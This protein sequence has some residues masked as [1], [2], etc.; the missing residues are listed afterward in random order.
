MLESVTS[1]RS[2]LRHPGPRSEAH[3]L[4]APSTRGSQHAR[5]R[6]ARTGSTHRVPRIIGKLHV[7]HGLG[8]PVKHHHLV[9]RCRPKNHD[10]RGGVVHGWSVAKGGCP[11]SPVAIRGRPHRMRADSRRFQPKGWAH[12]VFTGIDAVVSN[13]LRS[14]DLTSIEEEATSGSPC[15]SQ[16]TVRALPGSRRRRR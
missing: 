6:L 11:K 7:R 15:T 2:D 9:P 16:A 14:S 10:A 4:P 1:R 12:P 13:H 8:Q 5:R 3:T